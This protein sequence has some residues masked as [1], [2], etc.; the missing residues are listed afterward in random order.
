VNVY[1][2]AIEAVVRAFAEIVEFRTTAARAG[3]M[4]ALAIEI[5]PVPYV[6]DPAALS[7]TLSQRLLEALGL[8]IVVRVVPPG[9]LPR[10]EMKARRLVVEQ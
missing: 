9:T 7:A 6:A 8:S 3:A 2:T 5:E 4:R 10:F 1:P